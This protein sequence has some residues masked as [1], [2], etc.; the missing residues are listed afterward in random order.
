MVQVGSLPSGA[1]WLLVNTD[2]HTGIPK[3]AVRVYIRSIHL[4]VDCVWL[5]CFLIG[6]CQGLVADLLSSLLEVMMH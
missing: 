3:W 6:H 4:S 5:L 1:H 2:I